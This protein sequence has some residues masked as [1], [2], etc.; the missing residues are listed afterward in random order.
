MSEKMLDRFAR[1]ELSAAESRGLAEKALGDHDLFAELTS[2]AIAR[3]ELANLRPAKRTWPR[4]AIF[5]AAAAVILGVILCTA[6]RKSRPVRSDAAISGT[7]ILLARNADSNAAT[8]RGSNIDSREPRATGLVESVAHGI[9]SIDLGSVDGLAKDD[10]VDVIRDGQAIG[11]TRLTTIFRDHSRGEVANGSPIR[12]NDQ[13]R[14]PSGARMLATLDQI[15]AA[16]ARGESQK[17]LRIAQL[18][19]VEGLDADLS[20]AEDLNNAGVIAELHGD[21]LKA[22]TLYQ[23]G[24]QTSTSQADGRAI[25]KNLRR[26]RSAK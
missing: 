5:A 26:V 3:T 15:D 13:V 18:A 20:S 8:Y 17:A 21:S 23:R 4:I 24:S 2:T 6:Q 16:M 9:A 19:S 12:P 14:V 25:E 7:P 1:G 10:E 11:K 22:I